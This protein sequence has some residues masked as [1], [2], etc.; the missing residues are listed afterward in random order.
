MNC[1]GK[2]L[3]PIV[4]S[5]PSG[6]GPVAPLPPAPSPP[7]PQPASAKARITRAASAAAR[8]GRL[9][10]GDGRLVA[11]RA[12]GLLR[13]AR[14]GEP[15][16]APLAGLAL[17]P[18]AAAVL[19][20]DPVANRQPDPGAGVR[21]LAVQ[22]VERLEDLLGVARLHADAVVAHREP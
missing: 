1:S 10:S 13:G 6:V 19:L 2:F 16:R 11:R 3:V 22:A 9:M 4:I 5:G 21:P 8:L 12:V 20:D 17:R 15:E 7:P 14:Q 18:D